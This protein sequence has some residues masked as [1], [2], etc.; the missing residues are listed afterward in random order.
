MEETQIIITEPIVVDYFKANPHIDPNMLFVLFIDIIKQVSTN[1]SQT[2]TN[3]N[4][5]QILNRLSELNG[6]IGTVQNEMVSNIRN[7]TGKIENIILTDRDRLGTILSEKN[8]AVVSTTVMNVNA[9]INDATNKHTT[10]LYK[11]Q[12]DIQT[13]IKNTDDK[14]ITE[15]RNL[16]EQLTERNNSTVSSTVLNVHSV[17][18]EATDKYTNNLYKVQQDIQ[19][20]IKN[21]DDKTTFELRNLKEH[22][23]ETGRKTDALATEV[24]GF[25][26]KYKHNSSVKGNISERELYVILQQVFP[27]DELLVC[28]KTTASCDICVNRSD[29][30]KPSILFENKDYGV[31]VDREEIKKFERDLTTQRKHGI[32]ISQN[33]PITFK[34]NFHID[35]IDG[36][37]HL[38]LPNAN[39][40]IDRI[41]VAVDIV[42]HL[43][44]KIA[45]ETGMCGDVRICSTELGE[46]LQEYKNF[47]SR[48]TR[49]L[50]Y[51]RTSAKL[52]TDELDAMALPRIQTLLINT[53]NIEKCELT[54]TYC[55]AFTGKNKA[56]LGA[57]MK[58]CK[59]NPNPKKL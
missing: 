39:Y 8:N 24:N 44:Q 53:G 57:H 11:V 13:Q 52:W 12:Q 6:A 15:I 58:T 40:D 16:K 19:S 1:L 21:T 45:N 30:T 49:L 25:L 29:H 55:A 35:I 28:S 50:E 59:A 4:I 48:K 27:A 18:N 34:S 23:N 33:S 54:C 43:A 46:I 22:L 7:Q 9:A 20:Q 31:S 38:Y 3:V 51:I 42:D 17:I 41:K 32:F 10:S 5:N 14:T 47:A 56:S 26:N 37:I 2:I 36:L